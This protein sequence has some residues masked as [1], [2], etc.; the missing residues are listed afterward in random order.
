MIAWRLWYG[1]MVHINRFHWNFTG[2]CGFYW[3]LPQIWMFSMEAILYIF[4]IFDMASSIMYWLV[5][6]NI[7]IFPYIGNVIIPIDYIIFFRGVAGPPTRCKSSL[8]TFQSLFFSGGE[9]TD[10]GAWV[11]CKVVWENTSAPLGRRCSVLVL[12][13][14]KDSTW[15]T[16]LITMMIDNVTNLMMIMMMICIDIYIHNV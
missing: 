6:W 13:K 15:Y 11:V 2:N 3:L 16:Y 12:L 7:F 5:V 8:Q 10:R 4:H 14:F 9:A 1:D